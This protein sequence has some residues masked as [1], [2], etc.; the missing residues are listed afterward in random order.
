MAGGNN[1]EDANLEL[2][3]QSRK[4]SYIQYYIEKYNEKDNQIILW[5]NH[6][7]ASSIRVSNFTIN[8]HYKSAAKWSAFD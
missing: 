2:T 1:L 4:L 8:S 7:G 3:F 6:F 5:M